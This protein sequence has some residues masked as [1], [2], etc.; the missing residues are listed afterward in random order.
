MKDPSWES[1]LNLSIKILKGLG[2]LL[3]G[4]F[5]LIL[6]LVLAV[7]LIPDNTWRGPI[8]WASEKFA[9]HKIEILGSLDLD[10]Q[11]KEKSF[12]VK[13]TRLS[14]EPADK[15]Y[16]FETRDLEF[17]S[18]LPIGRDLAIERVFLKTGRLVWD[19]VPRKKPSAQ[20]IANERHREEK[21]ET[22][23]EQLLNKV[24]QVKSASL[25]NFAI[26]IR[27]PGKP[28]VK[29]FIKELHV[30]TGRALAYVKASADGEVSSLP[31]KAN[32]ETGALKTLVVKKELP[33]KV[34]VDLDVAG[35]RFVL[36]VSHLPQTQVSRFELEIVA[37]DLARLYQ[38]AGFAN[39]DLEEVTLTLAGKVDG[40]KTWAI[41]NWEASVGKSRLGGFLYMDLERKDVKAELVSSLIQFADFGKMI[42]LGE[43]VAAGPGQK[44]S[45][46]SKQKE[47]A[48][49]SD[50]ANMIKE[51]TVD[52]RLEV[53]RYR[54]PYIEKYLRSANLQ[55]KLSDGV[56]AIEPLNV[57]S[58]TGNQKISFWTKVDLAEALGTGRYMFR[59]S[60]LSSGRT[61][62][63]GLAGV[64]V[65]DKPRLIADLVIDRLDPKVFDFVTGQ[66]KPDP[67]SFA[68]KTPPN[69]EDKPEWV[70][71]S[72]EALPVGL[73][74]KMRADVQIELRQYLAR[75]SLLKKATLDLRL[76]GGRLEID[77]LS[78]E[79]KNQGRLMVAA[80]V[81]A[82]SQSNAEVAVTFALDQFDLGKLSDNVE[83]QVVDAI[84][85]AALFRGKFLGWGEIRGE[86]KSFNQIARSLDGSLQLSSSEG[87]VNIF[88][89]EALGFDVT[90]SIGAL[91]GKKVPGTEMECSLFAF[92]IR[93]G[94]VTPRAAVVSTADSNVALDGYV[95]LASGNTDLVLQTF[96]KDISIGSVRS[97]IGL[98][99]QIPDVKVDVSKTGIAA[100]VGAA[101][102]LGVFA[103]PLAAILPLI[104][105]SPGD[106]KIC[107]FYDSE[108]KSMASRVDNLIESDLSNVAH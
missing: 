80:D 97:P 44:K 101:I 6:I 91:L 43:E 39:K 28:I 104:E 98:K 23:W 29:S 24:P 79:M 102:A 35:N 84:T 12:A 3:A 105:L 4:I 2:W 87:K 45:T 31:V 1:A 34:N 15:S 74:G 51:W 36:G 64:E 30:E 48:E 99:G 103:T 54:G 93:D 37:K 100:R 70:L 107:S 58:A 78:L 33:A 46:D 18:N 19:G 16:Y 61:L 83:G 108:I 26:Q 57:T 11:F 32:I 60:R 17:V 9:G 76:D 106:E 27:Q 62:V 20:D 55:T 96:P 21:D 52:L 94:I 89:I 92:N 67:K 68:G 47:P 42:P 5:G 10:L 40:G 14:I 22:D 95:D 86:G 71:R 75:E 65:D 77:P 41:P 85:P 7:I 56:L 72:T 73:L 90:E 38:F 53:Q 81:V 49:Q 88:V 50:L 69:Q 63:T 13:A 82:R 66:S 59:E 25:Q 8:A